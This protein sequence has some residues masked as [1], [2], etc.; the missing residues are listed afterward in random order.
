MRRKLN[1]FLLFLL[2]SLLSVTLF[3]CD[4][5]IQAAIED[6]T[7]NGEPKIVS[8]W[9]DPKVKAKVIFYEDMTVSYSDRSLTYEGKPTEKSG[10]VTIYDGERVF[11]KWVIW[12][13]SAT[14]LEHNF[15][16]VE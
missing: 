15:T 11:D 13:D 14:G 3:S 10:T 1:N 12:R 8:T 4:E 2:L 9:E 6:A 5:L 16:R 7:D